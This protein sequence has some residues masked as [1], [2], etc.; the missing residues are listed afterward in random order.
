MVQQLLRAVCAVACL[1]GAATAR[2]Q[3]SRVNPTSPYVQIT[4]RQQLQQGLKCRRP[5]EFQFVNHVADLVEQGKL[6]L[7]LVNITFDWSRK[8][9]PHIPFVYFQQSLTMLATKKGYKL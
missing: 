4:L 6:P 2:A 1:A 9:N 7:D 5:I 8:R 3:T